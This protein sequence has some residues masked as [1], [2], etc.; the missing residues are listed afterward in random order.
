MG[1]QGP[2][3]RFVAFP[4]SRK[5]AES[6]YL[7]YAG[8]ISHKSPLFRN[9]LWKPC[10]SPL[11]VVSVLWRNWSGEC[12]KRKAYQAQNKRARVLTA[13]EMQ[14]GMKHWVQF[15]WLVDLL[16]FNC[17][18]ERDLR[19][20]FLK[21][22]PCVPRQAWCHHKSPGIPSLTL[23]AGHL[24]ILPFVPL[25]LSAG[26][27]VWIALECRTPWRPRDPHAGVAV[28]ATCI[29]NPSSSSCEGLLGV[30]PCPSQRL[31]SSICLWLSLRTGHST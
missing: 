20:L 18:G 1:I 31:G 4:L 2:E 10:L 30:Q 14:G 26:A 24:F 11:R 23:E 5:R 27:D 12:R 7:F 15:G 16:V 25:G 28:P 21:P 22:G 19:L 29:S 6:S 9:V 17:W 3:K 8:F 13:L